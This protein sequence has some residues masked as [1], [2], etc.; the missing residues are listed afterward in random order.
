MHN[1]YGLDQADGLR[2]LLV[3]NQTRLITVVAGKAGVGRSSMTLNLA[4]ALARAG[5]DVLVLDENFGPN[6]LVDR[7]M[8]AGHH[9][10]FD[11]AQGRCTLPQAVLRA[12]G[13]AVLPSARA[14]RALSD[15]PV[16]QQH[17][18]EQALR[19][20]SQGVD[21][22]LVDAA[23]L[24][25]AAVMSSSMAAGVTLLVVVDGTAS[26]ITESYALIKRLALENAKLQFEIVVNKVA[27]ESEARTVFENMAKVA[28]RHLAAHLAYLGFIPHDAKVSRATQ[29]GRAVV[30][31]FPQ[32]AAAQAYVGLAQK[33][34]VLPMP[35]DELMGGGIASMVQSL[36]R[37]MRGAELSVMVG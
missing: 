14:M 30:E 23:L 17:A 25:G 16:P 2:R 13:F 22:L 28:R 21:V 12:Q 35:Q 1:D 19:E 33:L 7:L 8:L 37:Q 5:K 3:G 32:A 6:N 9:D 27:N 10:L 36:L 15:M 24:G 11:V 31:A 4:S 18:M 20:A 29:L 26:G 34:V